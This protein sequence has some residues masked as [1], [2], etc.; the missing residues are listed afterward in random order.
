MRACPFDAASGEA[1]VQQPMGQEEFWR[2]MLLYIASNTLSSIPWAIP[3]GEGEIETMKRQARDVLEFSQGFTRP[4]P[5]WYC[6]KK[7]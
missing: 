7:A 4:V 3:F 5:L 2:R 1:E 6:G